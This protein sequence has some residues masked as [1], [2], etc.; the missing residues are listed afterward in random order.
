VFISLA[1]LLNRPPR[2]NCSRTQSLPLFSE[3]PFDVVI[4]FLRKSPSCIRRVP[5]SGEW[6]G[7]PLRLQE[8]RPAGGQSGGFTYKRKDTFF[9]S[10][11]YPHADES[12]EEFSGGGPLAYARTQGESLFLLRGGKGEEYSEKL[13]A[14]TERFLL[15]GWKKNNL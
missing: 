9:L 10:P 14:Q 7:R 2:G 12:Q 13:T 8:I 4:G 11:P 15:P 3:K 6:S 1:I 5:R